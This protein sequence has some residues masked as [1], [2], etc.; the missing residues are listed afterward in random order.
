MRKLF[1][2]IVLMVGLIVQLNAQIADSLR[3][4]E[5]EEP[6]F[7]LENDANLSPFQMR[8]R[9]LQGI[10]P[11]MNFSLTDFNAK[12]EFSVLKANPNAID[13]SKSLSTKQSFVVNSNLLG[14]YRQGKYQL[15]DKMSV[16]S[17]MVLPG[18]YYGGYNVPIGNYPQLNYGNSFEVG[19]K[20][21]D[22]FSIR[23]GFGVGR[24]DNGW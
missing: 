2:T 24:Y 6:N 7:I 23:A 14:Y 15:S 13:F 12:P 21:S 16:Y 4:A 3:N 9:D 20:F 22:K 11:A 1:F 10:P 19:Y 17:S 5:V 8:F 18:K